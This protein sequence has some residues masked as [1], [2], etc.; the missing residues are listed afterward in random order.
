MQATHGI[1]G[2]QSGRLVAAAIPTTK[3]Q[4]PVQNGTNCNGSS[5]VTD[6]TQKAD[7]LVQET[8]AR[9]TSIVQS[10][11]DAVKGMRLHS[12]QEASQASTSSDV[13]EPVRNLNLSRLLAWVVVSRDGANTTGVNREGSIRGTK[14]TKQGSGQDE[15]FVVAHQEWGDEDQHGELMTA[16]AANRRASEPDHEDLTDLATLRTSI[17]SIIQEASRKLQVLQRKLPQRARAALFRALSSPDSGNPNILQRLLSDTI[18]TRRS[19]A[20]KVED[21]QH[22]K[23]SLHADD[24]HAAGTGSRVV[25]LPAFGTRPRSV[26][27]DLY[28]AGQIYYIDKIRDHDASE[29][30]PSTG[31]DATHSLS[32]FGLHSTLTTAMPSDVYVASRAPKFQLLKVHPDAPF[33]SR[34]L[35]TKT[36]F[37]EHRSKAYRAA[38]N[39]L[40]D[41]EL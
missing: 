5:I 24:I 15:G 21:K 37:T 1:S 20:V 33:F 26:V 40:L 39:H 34:I 22:T 35:L 10:A 4:L 31:A 38:L 6:L 11:K 30:T 3:G 25:G 19:L 32:T 13:K 16:S 8:Q 12:A 17:Q 23:A 7:E 41:R 18:Y 27:P 14:N 36:A 2:F 28:P 9:V 29:F